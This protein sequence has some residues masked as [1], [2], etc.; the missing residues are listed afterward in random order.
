MPS[1]ATRQ[2]HI[3]GIIRS[4]QHFADWPP[5][6]GTHSRL[7]TVTRPLTISQRMMPGTQ[8]LECPTLHTV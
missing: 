7:D 5:C 6:P 3:A 8:T 1:Q 2:D 4:W